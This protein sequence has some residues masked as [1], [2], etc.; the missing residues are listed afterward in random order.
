MDLFVSRIN[1]Q[2]MRYVSWRPDPAAIHIDALTFPWGTQFNYAFPPFSLIGRVLQKMKEEEAELILVNPCWPTKAWFPRVLRRIVDTPLVL[3]KGCLWLP[4]KPHL[5]HPLHNK[6]ELLAYKLSGSHINWQEFRQR[7]PSSSH[8]GECI[9]NS[10]MRCTGNK[11]FFAASKWGARIQFQLFK[12]GLSYSTLNVVRSALSTI[13]QV[14][15]KPVWQHY[16]VIRFLKAVFNQ[17]LALPK[18][19]VTWDVDLLLKYL[20]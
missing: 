9:P 4:Q 8:H 15:D 20:K 19:E 2:V 3:P 6:L 11:C 18:T 7:W 12:Q 16:L 17:R 10:S 1:A 13:I 14:G 5:H